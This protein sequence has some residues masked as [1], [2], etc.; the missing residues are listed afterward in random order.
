MLNKKYYK[1]GNFQEKFNFSFYIFSI[2]IIIAFL[3]IS[4]L[5]ITRRIGDIRKTT[6]QLE[7]QL[8]ILEDKN[9]QLKAGI[10]QASQSD[11]TEEILR[12]KGLLEKKGEKMVVIL[13]PQQ[14]KGQ[15]QEQAKKS[16]WDQI[17]EI[18]KLRD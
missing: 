8:K 14:E 4:N 13:F 11:Y 17:L 6:S 7:Q 15:I 16:I 12:E 2:L 10:S 3:I 9:Q 1:K 18:L 5:K